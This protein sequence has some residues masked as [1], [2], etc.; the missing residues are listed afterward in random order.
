MESPR[1]LNYVIHCHITQDAT[2]A[3]KLY[4]YYTNDSL[5]T[6]VNKLNY[7]KLQGDGLL[8]NRI[9]P[10]SQK[11]Q[12]QITYNLQIEWEVFKLER[13]G[14]HLLNSTNMITNNWV[15]WHQCP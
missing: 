4:D 3:S 6:Y 7:C 12:P 1:L 11:Y 9:L 5:R 13:S 2:D 15:K 8:R 14:G 10:Q